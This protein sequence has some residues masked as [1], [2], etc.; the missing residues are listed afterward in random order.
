MPFSSQPM[1][2]SIQNG[3]RL[4]WMSRDSGRVS[5]TLHGPAGQVRACSAAWCWTRHVLLAAEAAADE[6]V[7]HADLVRAEQEL[8]LVQRRVR[9]TGRS[10]VPSHSHPG[11]C[12]E[13]AHSGSRKACSVHGVSKC[14]ENDI[15]GVLRWPVRVAARDMLIRL[16]VRLF[17]VNTRGASSATASGGLWTA[18][19][20]S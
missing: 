18:G 11:R 4:G 1:V 6:L 16:H 10:K 17:L 8:A 13:T 2:K 14:C 3:W 5:F 12:S 9:G 20:G 15:F 19:S 7:L